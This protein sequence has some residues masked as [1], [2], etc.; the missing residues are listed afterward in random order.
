[1][2]QPKDFNTLSMAMQHPVKK[3]PTHTPH[4]AAAGGG[5]VP[6]TGTPARAGWVDHRDNSSHWC[7]AATPRGH[8]PTSRGRCHSGAV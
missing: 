1:M 2:L 5:G 3:K 4:E 6:G 7:D 8:P